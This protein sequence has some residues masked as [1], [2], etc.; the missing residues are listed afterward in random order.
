MPFSTLELYLVSD[1]GS[2]RNSFHFTDTAA[3]TFNLL[4]SSPRA[5]EE[6]EGGRML[7]L[8]AVKSA[9]DFS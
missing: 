9:H 1:I 5:E 7:R 4:S 3:T 2:T 6:E 8:T